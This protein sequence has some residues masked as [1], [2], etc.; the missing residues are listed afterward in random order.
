MAKQR[1]QEKARQA[2]TEVYREHIL[3]AAEQIFAERGF[4]NA[5]LQDISA[6]A[7][8]SMGTIYAVF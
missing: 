1:P 8:V 6:L 3:E 4:E 5:K 7:G 2:R